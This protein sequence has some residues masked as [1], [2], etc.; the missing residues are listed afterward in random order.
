MAFTGH[1][2]HHLC[3]Q[4][5]QALSQYLSK[6]PAELQL[7]MLDASSE[8]VPDCRP[9]SS[10][11][12]VECGRST[13]G[14]NLAPGRCS[15]MGS[16]ASPGPPKGQALQPTLQEAAWQC[17]Q[18]SKAVLQLDQMEEHVC[19][20]MKASQ[21]AVQHAQQQAT[22]IADHHD[23]TCARFQRQ[24]FRLGTR[25]HA[26]EQKLDAQQHMQH[27]ALRQAARAATVQR[28]KQHHR[29]R[30]SSDDDS[31]SD[32]SVGGQSVRPFHRPPAPVH[33]TKRELQQKLDDL[34]CWSERRVEDLEA[35]NAQLKIALNAREKFIH[36]SAH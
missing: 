9:G 28:L 22:S 36:G 27:T 24:V 10:Q 35:E 23:R 13:A 8:G 29:T 33:L 21:Q 25:V 7:D 2:G 16:S 19:H 34:C 14:A 31:L 5:Q 6:G 15:G 1:I 20:V 12:E 17:Q 32:I 4:Q 3:S 30:N 18:A 11:P 26:L